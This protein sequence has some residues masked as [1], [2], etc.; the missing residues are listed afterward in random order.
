MEAAIIY[1]HKPNFGL[2]QAESA[3][4][5]S[6]LNVARQGDTLILTWE[7]EGPKF[8]VRLIQGGSVKSQATSIGRA[9]IHEG[10]LRHCDSAFEIAFKDLDEVLDESKTF[11][12][13]QEAL[14][15]ATDGVISRT[16]NEEVSGPE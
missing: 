12:Q 5:E 13:I 4:R 1:F 6:K 10:L 16:W 14:Q 15:T 11:I 8:S 3:L 7:A 9:T 2:D